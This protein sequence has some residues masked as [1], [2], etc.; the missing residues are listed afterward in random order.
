ME[1]EEL[2]SISR[3]ASTAGVLVLVAVALVL[4]AAL[5]SVA[6]LLASLL[7]LIFGLIATATFAAVA[8]GDL[9]LIS[10]AFGILYIGL[11]IDFI[12]HITLR[13]QELVHAGQEV[14]TALPDAA[15]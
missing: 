3:G 14:A 10:V 12:I 4:Y 5:G 8:I 11:G 13:V 9:N 15:R 1:H 6:T 7:T 2:N